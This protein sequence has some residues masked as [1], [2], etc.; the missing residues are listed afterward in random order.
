MMRI[1]A[2]LTAVVLVLAP[3]TGCGGGN[4]RSG[5]SVDSGKAGLEDFSQFLK[6]LPADGKKPPAKMADFTPLEPMAPVAG[7]MLKT[8]SLVYIWGS[9]IGTGSAVIAYEKKVET[10]GGYVLLQDGTV[11]KMTADEFKAAPKAKK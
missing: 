9:G 2:A 5:A 11:K 7:D 4:A 10:E 1:S 6:N 3:L 8:G